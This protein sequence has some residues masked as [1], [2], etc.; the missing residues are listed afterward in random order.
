MNIDKI[1]SYLCDR[2]SLSNDEITMIEH[3]K[4]TDCEFRSLYDEMEA[5]M[6][7][8]DAAFDDEHV[9][10]NDLVWSKIESN[11]KNNNN[12]YFSK[13]KFYSLVAVAAIILI[14]CGVGLN[15]ILNSFSAKHDI[16]TIQT[17]TGSIVTHLSDGSDVTVNA[18]SILKYSGDFNKSN[19]D[20]TLDGEAWF[21]VKKSSAP[22][23][24]YSNKISVTALGTS[25]N[26]KSFGR[27]TVVTLNT[28]KVFVANAITHDSLTTLIPGEKAIIDENMNV[29][30]EPCEASS[31]GIW[32]ESSLEFNGD[33]F[34][35]IIY[36]LEK[37]H[38]VKIINKVKPNGKTYWMKMTE[39]RLTTTLEVF[40][41][42]DNIDYQIVGDTIILTN[43]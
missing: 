22:F 19:R 37:W 39:K 36:K 29:R 2:G 13:R 38:G 12:F 3:L 17:G 34:D 7:I 32:R 9:E 20:I 14:M 8:A 18:N 42:L 27:T 24:V 16:V 33:S 25:F 10:A 23:V 35:E 30:T 1:S 40:K 5:S 15:H 21:D 6:L 26:I 28:G 41:N 43:K 31:E 4:S 11:I